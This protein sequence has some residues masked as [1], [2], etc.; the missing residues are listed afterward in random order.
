MSSFPVH[1]RVVG[2]FDYMLEVTVDPDGA[3]TVN[4]GDHTSHAPR[5]GTL[6]R[7]Q[8]ERLQAALAHLGES[9]D[10]PAPDGAPGFM[11][12][13]TLG[14]GADGRVFRFWE[15]ALDEELALK[16]VVRELELI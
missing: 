15:G 8:R 1:Y 14:A 6:D 7:H 16:A 12:E 11:A 4:S 3:F 13:L 5:H 10:H 2:E 9:R